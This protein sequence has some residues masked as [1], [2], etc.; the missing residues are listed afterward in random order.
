MLKTFLKV[1]S[2]G[3]LIKKKKDFKSPQ[4]QYNHAWDQNYKKRD[5]RNLDDLRF[6]KKFLY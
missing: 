2:N 6:E 4:K 3:L 1:K 5:S